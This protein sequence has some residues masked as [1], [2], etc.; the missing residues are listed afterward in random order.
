MCPAQAIKKPP[1]R[2]L[3]DAVP[4]L[5]AHLGHGLVDGDPGVVD[6]D[7]QAA[8]LLDD[9]T[10]HA[11]AV[12]RL[13]DVPVVDGDR[14]RVLDVHV[15]REF[16]GRLVL[17]PV[18]GGDVRALLGQAMADGGPDAAG[19]P[20][21]QGHPVLQPTLR[22]GRFRFGRGRHGVAPVCFAGGSRLVADARRAT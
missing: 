5:V 7:V 19:S 15:F 4:V 6:Q 21:D 17:P 1:G 8:V 2:L 18:P 16:L 11:P 13:A 14:A 10:H 20:G 12:F 22:A 9:F 3:D